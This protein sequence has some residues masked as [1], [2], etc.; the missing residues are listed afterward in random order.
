M[1]PHILADRNQCLVLIAKFGGNLVDTRPPHLLDRASP[2][3][4]ESLGFMS[5]DPNLIQ[6]LGQW[7][8]VL[9]S[10]LGV[11]D[12]DVATSLCKERRIQNLKEDIDFGFLALGIRLRNLAKL[13]IVFPED[14][15]DNSHQQS[16][17]LHQARAA[18]DNQVDS[19][20][21]TSGCVL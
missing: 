6:M 20:Y 2:I 19:H 8:P 17:I 13:D 12:P 14:V 15:R 7:L 1:A 10:P 5:L 9:V 18:I 11:R 16:C 4:K 3:G 21:I